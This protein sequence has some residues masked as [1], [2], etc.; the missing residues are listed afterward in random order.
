MNLQDKIVG[1]A[2]AALISLV[3][4][5]L[6]ETWAIGKQIIKLQ[7]GLIVLEKQ[8][9]TIAIIFIIS[10]FLASCFAR[11]IIYAQEKKLH[12]ATS[13]IQLISSTH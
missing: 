4:W 1:L 9:K 2:L 10:Y 13:A 5:N 8:I 11:T 7:Q 12:R 6:H 3:G